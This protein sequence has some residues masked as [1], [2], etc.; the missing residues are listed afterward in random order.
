[1]GSR[2]NINRNSAQFSILY[3]PVAPRTAPAPSF[4]GFC[5]LSLAPGNLGSTCSH[6]L[7]SSFPGCLGFQGSLF[8]DFG[9]LLSG[10][11]CF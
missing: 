1:M 8:L 9:F 10:M 5:L 11:L 2:I 7:R 6:L 4:F 3:H